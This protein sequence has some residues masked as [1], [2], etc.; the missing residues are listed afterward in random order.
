[1]YVG[2]PMFAAHLGA[3]LHVA[4]E[5]ATVSVM[6]HPGL[7]RSFFSKLPSPFG[8]VRLSSIDMSLLHSTSQRSAFIYMNVLSYTLF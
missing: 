4:V 5:P 7:D 2:T 6:P 8:D 3:R 1:M